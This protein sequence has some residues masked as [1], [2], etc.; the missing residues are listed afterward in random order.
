MTRATLHDPVPPDRF[1]LRLLL[2]GPLRSA[3][4][5][6]PRASEVI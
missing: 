4:S 1:I 6:W 2:T 3:A 5:D